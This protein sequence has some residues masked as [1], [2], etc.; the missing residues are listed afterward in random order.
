MGGYGTNK[1]RFHGQS[2]V[3]SLKQLETAYDIRTD[4]WDA[5]ILWDVMRRTIW[6]YLCFTSHIIGI[7]SVEI[8]GSVP[9]DLDILFGIY[10]TSKQRMAVR[11]ADGNGNR[12]R[13]CFLSEYDSEHY[14]LLW[15]FL[16]GTMR[17]P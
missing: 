3:F 16:A 5:T 8:T 2:I 13:L 1:R 10:C 17:L 12:P 7:M 4:L 6:R 15:L 11:K 14:P 9:D